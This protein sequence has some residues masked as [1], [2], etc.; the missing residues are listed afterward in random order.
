MLDP[1]SILPEKPQ[2]ISRAMYERMVDA[3]VFAE[4]R[5][6]LIRGVIV[7]MSPRGMPHMAVI[8]KLTTLLAPLAVAGK[9]LIHAQGP[10]ALGDDSEP[11]P[12]F[13]LVPPGEAMLTSRR[14][15][16]ATRSVYSTFRM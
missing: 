7:E 5:V 1:Q 11:E 8:R 3:R 12:D 14:S 13:A 9:A 15:A 10:L 6:E 2:P 16:M 4:Q